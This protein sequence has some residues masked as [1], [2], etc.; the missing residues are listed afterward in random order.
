MQ[1]G[2]NLPYRVL[3]LKN[4]LAQKNIQDGRQKFKMAAIHFDYVPL[5]SKPSTFLNN[6]KNKLNKT[7]QTAYAYQISAL[8]I[9]F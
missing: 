7:S 1:L 3:N 2:M 4:I 6:L 8:Y 9:Y 5:S